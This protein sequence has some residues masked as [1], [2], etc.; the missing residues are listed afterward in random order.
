MRTVIVVGE[1][2][3]QQRTN[4]CCFPENLTLKGKFVMEWKQTHS[5]TW[6]RMFSS[7]K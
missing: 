2:V 3:F 5:F 4:E 6:G 1:R 7:Q